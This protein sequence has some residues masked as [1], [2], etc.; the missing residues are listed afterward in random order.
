METF[1]GRM[2]NEMYYGYENKYKS[3]EE[4]EKSGQCWRV[5][6]EDRRMYAGGG[7]LTEKID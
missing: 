6:T 3:F 7:E 2:K 4:F 5:P 1:F